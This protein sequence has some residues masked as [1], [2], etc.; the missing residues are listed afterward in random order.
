[1]STW[2]TINDLSEDEYFT[3]LRDVCSLRPIEALKK[4]HDREFKKSPNKEDSSS[5]ENEK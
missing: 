2:K 1:M 3:Y 5:N 4:A